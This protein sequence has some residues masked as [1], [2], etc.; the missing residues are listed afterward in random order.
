[1]TLQLLRQRPALSHEDSELDLYT[2]VQRELGYNRRIR[3][4]GPKAL[5]VPIGDE[6]YGAL[7][8]STLTTVGAQQVTGTLAS[9]NWN[10]MATPLR[11]GNRVPIWRPDGTNDWIEFADAD[12]WTDDASNAEPSYTW[13]FWLRVVAGA[14]KQV[15][16]GKTPAL[17]TTGTDWAM[18][19]TGAEK[20]IQQIWD[21]DANAYIGRFYNTALSGFVHIAITKSTGTTSAA[22]KIYVDGVQRDDGDSEAGT[23]VNQENGTT[24]VRLGAESDG[25]N[26]LSSYLAGADCGPLFIPGQV[27]SINQIKEDFRITS[28]PMANYLGT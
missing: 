19:L 20:I 11:G 12:F 24:V 1:V 25:G 8:G 6:R 13:I 17:G 2:R 7:S 5:I 27:A 22:N 4:L 18:W 14:A 28:G 3:N 9:G 15:I 23:Y 16:W 26:P 21:D 10:A